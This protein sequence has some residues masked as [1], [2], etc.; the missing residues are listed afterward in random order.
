MASHKHD[1]HN[2]KHFI[3]LNLYVH[4]TVAPCY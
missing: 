1:I 4:N 2:N 3:M